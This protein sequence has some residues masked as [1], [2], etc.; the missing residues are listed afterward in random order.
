MR[1]TTRIVWL[2]ISAATLRQFRLDTPNLSGR[3]TITGS[4]AAGPQ[5]SRLP[6][7]LLQLPMSVQIPFPIYG[8]PFTVGIDANA[9][10]ELAFTTNNASVSGSF[11]A[12]FDGNGGMHVDNGA[13]SASGAFNQDLS[14][15]HI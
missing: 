3:A 10:I 2:T 13:L 4:A 9:Q 11:D 7:S 5:T 8:I 12:H 1:T 14:L 15:I 6:V